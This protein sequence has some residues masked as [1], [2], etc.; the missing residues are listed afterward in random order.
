MT[1]D[2]VAGL[3]FLALSVT[4]GVMAV[5]IPLFPG[6]EYEAFTPRT[7]PIVLALAGAAI[8]LAMIVTAKRPA[9]AGEPED[10]GPS[11]PRPAW[12]QVGL[13]LLLMIVY[14]L[15]IQRLGFLASTMLFL[16]GGFLILGERRGPLLVAV[17]LAV[18]IGFWA[19]M[20]QL[21]GLYL[22]PGL[23]G[24]ALGLG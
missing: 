16:I 8:S 24:R 2:R 4:Y 9:A 20:T 11:G 18:S 12:G 5:D 23:V 21:L 14:G 10:E 13:L 15:T 1:K 17:A 3:L 7:L 22:A 19:I 6:M